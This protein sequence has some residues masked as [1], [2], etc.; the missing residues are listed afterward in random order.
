MDQSIETTGG[1]KKKMADIEVVN[2]PAPGPR[3]SGKIGGEVHLT[4]IKEST[5]EVVGST[6]GKMKE[7]ERREREEPK[8]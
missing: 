4:L 5:G 1:D 6:R 3:S 7:N 8:Y 2:E